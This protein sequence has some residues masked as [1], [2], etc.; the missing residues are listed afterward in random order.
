VAEFAA[1][2]KSPVES[3]LVD[4]RAGG[5]TAVT[6]GPSLLVADQRGRMTPTLE[7]LREATIPSAAERQGSQSLALGRLRGRRNPQ[8][9]LAGN[10][11]YRAWAIPYCSQYRR[12][13]GDLPFRMVVV[14]FARP[15]ADRLLMP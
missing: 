1:V 9:V 13:S 6:G 12:V 2:I 11:A 8:R 7:P 3:D 5:T 10:D 4:G 15:G 14:R